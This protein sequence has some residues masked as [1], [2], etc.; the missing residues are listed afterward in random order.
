MDQTKSQKFHNCAQHS[1]KKVIFIQENQV[2]SDT[3]SNLFYCTDCINEDLNFQAKNYLLIEQIIQQGENSI[4]QKWPPVNDYQLIQ[5]LIKETSK[6]DQSQYII[7]RVTN[8]F[9]ELKDEIIRKIE[10]CQK[11]M[12]NQ[13]QDLPFGKSQIIQQYQ[14]ISQICQLRSLINEYKNDYLF[15]QQSAQEKLKNFITQVELKKDQNTKQLQKLLEQSIKQQYL[16]NYE[17]PN[18]IKEQILSFVDKINFFDHDILDIQNKNHNNNES[19]CQNKINF[20]TQIM[21][22]ISNKSNFCSSEFLHQIKQQLEKLNPLFEGIPTQNMF[23]QGKKPIKFNKL[24]DEK[25]NQINEHVQ[26]QIQLQSNSNYQTEIQ[27]SK[28]IK[29]IQKIMENKLNFINQISQKAIINHLTETYPYLKYDGNTQI[30]QQLEKFDLFNQIDEQM[31]DDLYLLMKKKQELKN[32]MNISQTL[33]IK[34]S[35]KFKTFKKNNLD[36]IFS[37]FPIFD[38]IPKN[39][40]SILND[41]KLVKG[42]FN[43]GDKRIQIKNNNLNQYE[44]TI[45]EEQ[46][47]G[48]KINSFANCMSNIILDK[49]KKYIF[50]VQLQSMSSNILHFQIGL[51]QQQNLNVQKGF[52]DQQFVEFECENNKLKLKCTRF[53][54]YLKGKDLELPIESTIIELRVWLN[55]KVLQISDY[56]QNNYIVSTQNQNLEKLQNQKNLSFFVQQCNSSQKYLIK[57]ALIVEEFDD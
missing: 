3:D 22:L 11:K 33:K 53:N 36:R 51:M 6:F 43:D 54:K 34:N 9:T 42:T 39:E 23:I 12:I 7:Q 1:K 13:I 30:I 21:S 32:S 46:Y 17:L 31:I 55:G 16:V 37:Q 57:D 25:I 18:M 45:N 41:L 35:D 38:L 50:R 47:S 40:I 19:Q 29:D 5:K 20:S 4:I 2:S 48:Q 27:Q 28:F 24:T 56:P 8:Y 10:F 44:I 15:Q 52:E 26:H 14:Q 49:D